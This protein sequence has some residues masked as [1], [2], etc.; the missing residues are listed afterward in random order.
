MLSSKATVQLRKDAAEQWKVRY[1]TVH[2]IFRY[3][4]VNQY[5]ARTARSFTVKSYTI[6]KPYFVP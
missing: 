6:I 4:T 3:V 2:C 5:T 1:P